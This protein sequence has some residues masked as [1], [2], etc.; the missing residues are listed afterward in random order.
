MIIDIHHDTTVRHI[1]GQFSERYPYLKLVFLQENPKA[2]K[3]KPVAADL[4]INDFRRRPKVD[5]MIIESSDTITDVEKAFAKQLGLEV[6]ILRQSEGHWIEPEGAG[7]L[8]LRAQNEAG[9]AAA[10][11]IIHPDYDSHIENTEN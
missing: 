3:A 11:H 10:D 4:R 6:K 8:S 9:A 1:Q 2:S 5:S 7:G